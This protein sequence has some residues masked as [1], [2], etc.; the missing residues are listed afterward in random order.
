MRNPTLRHRLAVLSGLALVV[1]ALVACGDATPTPT[2]SPIDLATAT[3]TSAPSG[4]ASA[5]PAGTTT[6]SG[7]NPTAT[8]GAATPNKTGGGGTLRWSNEGV[9]DLDT[10][11]PALANASNSI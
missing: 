8:V 9:Q 10:L 5:T 7:T 2:T 3:S 11:D 6:V 1:P 4:A